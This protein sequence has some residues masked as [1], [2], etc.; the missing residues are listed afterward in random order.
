LNSAAASTEYSLVKYAPINQAPFAGDKPA[1]EVLADHVVVG[2]E[3]RQDVPV[4][5]RETC[6]YLGQQTADLKLGEPENAIQHRLE[7]RSCSWERM[8]A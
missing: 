2:L 4:A 5:R 8:I 1:I 3:H 6:D 7:V